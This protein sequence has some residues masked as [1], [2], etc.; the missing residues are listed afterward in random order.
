MCLNCSTV[1][2][3]IA[4]VENNRILKLEGNPRDPNSRGKLCA[5]GQAA[6]NMVEDPDRLL[7]PMRR[8]GQRGSGK[9]E[10][11]SWDEAIDATAKRLRRLRQE[12][13]PEALMLQ[14]GRD[15]TNGFLDRFTDA[16]G[17][18]NKLG[19]RGLCSL[20]KRMA[21][22]AAIGSSR[23]CRHAPTGGGGQTARGADG[24]L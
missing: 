4:K 5:K 22:R 2:G 11:I 1:C 7:Y 24:H 15:R 8:K 6:I 19:H 18:P 9:W 13:R 21:I 3:M 14:Y 17:T 12:G 23:P 16:F 10:R 20:N